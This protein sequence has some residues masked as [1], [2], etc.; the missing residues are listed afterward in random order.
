MTEIKLDQV[1]DNM[2]LPKAVVQR[3]RS[4]GAFAQRL[5]ALL[6]G[7]GFYYKSEGTIKA[8]YPKVE[9]KR[10]PGKKFRVF[11][12]VDEHDRVIPGVYGVKRLPLDSEASEPTEQ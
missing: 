11:K 7:Q 3:K 10:F 2:E 4:R 9:A 1:I 5:E 8:Q 6:V 12:A